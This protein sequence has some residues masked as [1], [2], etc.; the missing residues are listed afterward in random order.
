MLNSSFERLL[1]SKAADGNEKMQNE[2]AVKLTFTWNVPATVAFIE[3]ELAQLNVVG[4]QVRKP[5]ERKGWKQHQLAVKLQNRVKLSR[6]QVPP[7][8]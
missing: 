3:K 7:G 6:G 5:G 4:P 1:P 8:G 2:C